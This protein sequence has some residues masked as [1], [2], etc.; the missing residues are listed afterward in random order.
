MVDRSIL[1]VIRFRSVLKTRV[2][3]YGPNPD[4][5]FLDQLTKIRRLGLD[6][7][8]YTYLVELERKNCMKHTYLWTKTANQ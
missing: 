1:K 8:T 5:R 7:N 4:K 3:K 6:S 2:F